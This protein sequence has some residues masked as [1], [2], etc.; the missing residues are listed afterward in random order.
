MRADERK[1]NGCRRE[2]TRNEIHVGKRE[3]EEVKKIME[4]RRAERKEIQ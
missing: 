3:N 4:E 1:K 2:T